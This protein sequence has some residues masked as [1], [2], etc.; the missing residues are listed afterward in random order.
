MKQEFEKKSESEPILAN[1]LPYVPFYYVRHGQ[2]DWNAENRA[3]GQADIP[4]NAK[5]IQQAVSARNQ[6]TGLGITTICHSP[7]SRAKQTAELFNEVLNVALIE[8]EELC[9][10]NLGPY[11]GKVKEQ[12]FKDWRHGATLPETEQYQDFM[13]RAFQGITKALSFPGPVLIVAHGGVYWAIEQFVQTGKKEIP[14]CI[15]A[16]YEPVSHGK[17]KFSLLNLSH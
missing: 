12:W 2:T 16:F 13:N 4:L 15:P 14:N 17:W 3:M 1:K 5:G 9:E 8:I 7:L 6:L 11:Q 10:F